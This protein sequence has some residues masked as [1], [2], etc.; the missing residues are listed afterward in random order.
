MPRMDGVEAT[1]LIR[2]QPATAGTPI[3]A[4]TASVMTDERDRYLATGF[5]DVISKPI[6]QTE[7]KACLDQWIR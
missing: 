7:L 6:R 4:F 5:Q 3:I 2:A 1:R